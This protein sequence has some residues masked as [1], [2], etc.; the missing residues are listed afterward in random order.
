MGIVSVNDTLYSW[1]AYRIPGNFLCTEYNRINRDKYCASI[2]VTSALCWNTFSLLPASVWFWILTVSGRDG[3]TKAEA[4]LL[5][6][7]AT[8]ACAPCD[9]WSSRG[10]AYALRLMVSSLV[11][12]S[13]ARLGRLAGSF[14]HMC[15]A[16]VH[17]SPREFRGF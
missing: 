16:V 5:Y 9:I 17:A 4:V 10:D 11:A 12:F 8:C 3:A 15:S 6:H 13:A 2:P 14:H 7:A 1:A